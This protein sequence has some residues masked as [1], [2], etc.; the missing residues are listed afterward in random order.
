MKLN[1][2]CGKQMMKGKNW[3]NL[4]YHNVHR[5]DVIHNLEVFPYPFKNNTFNEIH[6]SH[7]LEHLNNLV[8]VMEELHRICKNK[9]IIKIIT[10]HATSFSSLSPLTHKRSFSSI[11]FDNFEEGEWEIYSDKI[12]KI[13]KK[14]LHWF[15][16]RDYF[17]M[18]T[19]NKLI[20]KIININII[21]S[22]RFLWVLLGGFDEIYYELEVV[23]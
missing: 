1:L 7:V 8:R 17:V 12:F 18:R 14:E 15:R 22:E 10:P 3:I 11:T 4:D 5:A 19:I 9:A 20:E 6:C 16:I 21:F 13:N 23:K 2:G